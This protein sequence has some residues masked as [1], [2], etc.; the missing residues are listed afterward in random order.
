MKCWTRLYLVVG[1]LALLGCGGLSDAEYVGHLEDEV[2]VDCGSFTVNG[3]P[4]VPDAALT[5]MQDA[6]DQ[7][8]TA[9]LEQTFITDEGGQLVE[10][11]YTTDTPS[12]WGIVR[13]VDSRDD[14]WGSQTVEHTHCAGVAFSGPTVSG[15]EFVVAT[16]CAD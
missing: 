15:C 1:S 4:G 12:G 2:S 10:D 14:P 9:K 3:C 16:E 8:T 5:C 11:L 13:V 6:L 7:R